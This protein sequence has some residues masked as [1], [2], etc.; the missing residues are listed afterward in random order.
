MLIEVKAS[1]VG[2]KFDNLVN[3]EN[4]LI[5]YDYVGIAQKSKYGD[6]NNYTSL[7]YGTGGPNTYQFYVK[8]NT[9]V[10]PDPALE[11]TEDFEYS[12]QAV[13]LTDEVTHSGADVL[14]YAKGAFH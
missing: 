2:F 7:L 13:V 11:D 10:R 9:V 4:T 8:N 5:Y 3:F 1:W 12:Q 6:F 14:V